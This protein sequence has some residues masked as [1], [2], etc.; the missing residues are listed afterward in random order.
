LTL[1]LKFPN[2]ARRNFRNSALP[3]RTPLKNLNF[4][5]LRFVFLSQQENAK[6]F[7]ILHI[8]FDILA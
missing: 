3:N 4:A 6:P 1:A 5:K 2:Q 8:A 7:H